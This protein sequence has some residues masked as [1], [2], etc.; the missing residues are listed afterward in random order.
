MNG[1]EK[2]NE[3]DSL[4][5]L[6]YYERITQF[7]R[8]STRHSSEGITVLDFRPLYA[9]AIHHIQRQLA[10][11]VHDISNHHVTDSQLDVICQITRKYTDCLRDFEYIHA[12][13]WHTEFVKDIAASRIDNGPGSKFQA[14]LLEELKLVLDNQQ[15]VMYSDNDLLNT[16][17]GHLK[18]H[19]P[20]RGT[21]RRMQLAALKKR[22]NM[23]MTL[24]RLVFAVLGGLLI[25]IPLSLIS[26][27]MAS[28]KTLIIVGVSIIVFALAIAL[29]SSAAP[30]NL[31]AAT[32]AYAAV[33]VVFIAN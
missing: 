20:T 4:V 21:K 5:S 16:F 17:N 13:R 2:D 28:Q 27:P 31:L 14:V 30:E 8:G 11:Q 6:N 3:L 18:P 15:R 25:I 26:A 10:K 24:Y 33:L 32:A 12:N 22:V 1:V 29:F 19:V 23:A 9:V 7:I